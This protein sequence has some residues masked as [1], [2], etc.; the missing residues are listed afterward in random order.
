MATVTKA[1]IYRDFDLRFLAHPVTGK[2]VTKKNSDSVKQAVKNLILTN[3]Y[4]RPYRPNF[5]SSVRAHLFENYTAFTEESLQYAIKTALTN[6]EPRIELLDIRFGGDPDHNSLS[7]GIIFR[8]I[9]TTENVT[10][11]LNLERVR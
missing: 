5:G 3:F 11:N 7:I 9:N 4:E 1:V 6:F 8:P 10:L 2:L